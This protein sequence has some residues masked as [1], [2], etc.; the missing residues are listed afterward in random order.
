M[1]NSYENNKIL[2]CESDEEEQ[3]QQHQLIRHA[4][5]RFE[6]FKIVKQ[7]TSTVVL[8][9]KYIDYNCDVE[10][11]FK[12]VKLKNHNEWE[13]I[14]WSRKS[15]CIIKNL[16]QNTCY[17]IKVL[18]MQ[19]LPDK[20]EAV[21]SSEVLK[22]SMQVVPSHKTFIRS[23]VQK[24]QVH[25]LKSYLKLMPD[26]LTLTFKSHSA[27][28]LAVLQNDLNVAKFLLDEG[29]D[30]NIGIPEIKRTPLQV[31]IFHGFLDM[32]DLLL[33]YKADIRV[34]DILGLNVAHHAVDSNKIESVQ[35]CI[36]TL[37]IHT[38]TK[39]NNGYTLLLRAIV[40]R[41]NY[42]IVR[43]LLDQKASQSVRDNARLSILQ[44]LRMINDQELVEI[45]LNYKPKSKSEAKLKMKHNVQKLI[46]SRQ[47]KKEEIDEE[48][49]D[50]SSQAATVSALEQNIL[51][52]M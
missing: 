21:N 36:E 4:K 1:E 12:V 29:V 5:S 20:F 17:N 9:W 37:N 35:Y 14:C 48:T 7:T 26:Y 41:S 42:D 40:C 28:C 19:Q 34:K 24:S 44:H 27:L 15:S 32:A 31:A 45:L 8:E 10:K 43:Y 2:T 18:V 52:K 23:A 6:Y 22:C 11:V 46:M 16:E 3:E 51:F 25:L 30:V 47:M 50:E 49:G 33:S 38:E 13:T 39:D